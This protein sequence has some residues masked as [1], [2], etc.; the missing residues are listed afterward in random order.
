MSD[1]Q[2]TLR[3]KIGLFLADLR[4]EKGYTQQEAAEAIG[5]TRV[6]V[7]KLERGEDNY[8]IDMLISYMR[9][10]NVHIELSELTAENNNRTR[11]LDE[12]APGN[13]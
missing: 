8:S 6:S 4:A 10:L 5:S 9:L 7:G 3:K 13:N 2:T 1:Y 12:D 11:L